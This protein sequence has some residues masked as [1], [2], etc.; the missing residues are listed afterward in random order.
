MWRALFTAWGRAPGLGEI[1]VR[2]LAGLPVAAPFGGQP[3]NLR[4]LRGQ[5]V[6]RPRGNGWL[7]RSAV[8]G[9]RRLSGY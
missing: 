4:F 5:Q 1:A 7:L 6:R 2:L 3:R 8:P 9:R